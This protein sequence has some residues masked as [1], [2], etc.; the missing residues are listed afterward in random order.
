MSE[1]LGV[2]EDTWGIDKMDRRACAG[3]LVLCAASAAAVRLATA[4][5]SPPSAP[6]PAPHPLAA[7]PATIFV[8]MDRDKEQRAK[9]QRNWEILKQKGV[10]VALI[11][12]YPRKVYPTY[13]SDRFGQYITVGAPVW[14]AGW[15]GVAPLLD[16]QCLL[17]SRMPRRRSLP[18][19]PR[20][21]PQRPTD[22]S[23][24]ITAALLK[25][26][27]I[28]KDGYVFENPRW[29]AFSNADGKGGVG[30]FRSPGWAQRS[31]Y[32]HP[33]PLPSHDTGTTSG[34]GCRSCRSWCP[35]WA[36]PR[37]RRGDALRCLACVP[38]S[39]PAASRADLLLQSVFLP[40]R[41]RRPRA[42]AAR[43]APQ[44]WRH[45][46]RGGVVPDEPGLCRPR[47]R[48]RLRRGGL[49]LVGERVRAGGGRTRGGRGMTGSCVPVR[50]L[51]WCDP[52]AA[53][54]SDC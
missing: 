24:K 15:S 34:P 14:L 44:E 26:K 37:V 48:V 5:R 42:L 25:M 12:V 41:S 39:T 23:K 1:A 33:C 21:P 30:S 49:P 28:G 53:A 54:V 2:D 8:S 46:R 32:L 6:P 16:W 40:R 9:I 38:R 35:S 13:F 50:M 27:M 4:S 20:N 22:I 7:Y 10:P 11:K 18:L 29:E 52:A 47:D 36:A 17:A 19:P 51:C 43:V 45:A 3:C 31:L